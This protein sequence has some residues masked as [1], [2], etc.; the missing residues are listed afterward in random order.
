MIITDEIKQQLISDVSKVLSWSQGVCADYLNCETLIDQ[1]IEGKSKFIDKFT[2]MNDNGDLTLITELDEIV[3]LELTQAEKEEKFEHFISHLNSWNNEH[4]ALKRFLREEQEGFFLNSV[5]KDYSVNIGGQ[6][7]IIQKGSKLLKAFKYFIKNETDRKYWQD[8]ASTYIQEGK[9]RGKMCLSVHPLDYLSVSET[10]YKWRSCHALDGEYRA[11]NLNY[12]ADHTTL[13]CYIKG[14]EEALLPNFPS[15]VKWNSKKWRCLLYVSDGWDAFFAG[16]QYPMH[17]P[18]MLD[19]VQKI[20]R[21]CLGLNGAWSG[22]HDDNITSFDYEDHKDTIHLSNPYIP[23]ASR[24]Y[25]IRNLIKDGVNTHHYNDLLRSSC[26]TPMYCWAK[27][28]SNL[29]HFNIG[30]EVKCL[31]CNQASIPEHDI[32]LCYDCDSRSGSNGGT[33]SDCGNYVRSNN[34]IYIENQDREICVHCYEHYYAACGRCD[35]IYERDQM[36]LH[37]GTFYCEYC[38]NRILREQTEG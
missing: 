5:V 29:I 4:C 16:R 32:M 17:L 7:K 6:E 26:Y 38:Y 13:I 12:M 9:I 18:N 19:M 36:F 20:A 15:D 8:L 34:L 3:E 35:D 24:I 25:P 30:E 31:H 37:N 21:T 22:W 1:W 28:N 11:G 2:K 10:T 27:N 33:C 14:E 23:M